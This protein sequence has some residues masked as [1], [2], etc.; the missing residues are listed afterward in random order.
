M[1]RSIAL[2]FC[3]MSVLLPSVLHAQSFLLVQDASGKIIFV[4]DED[5]SESLLIS[6]GDLP[7][8]I[9]ISVYVGQNPSG[10]FQFSNVTGIF[11]DMGG[12]GNGIEDVTLH[13]ATINGDVEMMSS[14][15]C[16]DM[17][18]NTNPVFGQTNINGDVIY[19]GTSGRDLFRLTDAQ[20]SG[21]VHFEGKQD[22]DRFI[23]EHT[24][25]GGQVDCRTGI[26]EGYMTLDDCNI[27]SSLTLRSSNGQDDV[28]IDFCD[29]H[30]SA[31]IRLG[32]DHDD[33]LVLNTIFRKSVWFDGGHGNDEGNQGGNQY[34]GKSFS[35]IWNFEM[36]NFGN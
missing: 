36:G 1:T 33:I 18:L 17:R 32:S 35:F 25:V 19:R 6:D 20:V 7:N 27:G 23:L 22:T 31:N 26:G 34:P 3:C 4:G 15:Y 28:M 5:D 8:E 10:L 21:S 13:G 29:V 2:L 24:D 30:G 12:C 16:M 11:M 9:R 14:G